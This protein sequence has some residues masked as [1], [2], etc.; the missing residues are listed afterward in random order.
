MLHLLRFMLQQ[1]IKPSLNRKGNSALACV[2]RHVRD[3]EFRYELIDMLLQHGADANCVGKDGSVPLIV[4]FVPLL[5]KGLLH[6][7][8]HTKKVS[9]LN[10]VRILCKFGANPNCAWRTNLTPLHVLVFSASEYITMMNREED[11][12]TAFGFI[13]QVLTILLQHNLDPNVDFSQRNQ[14]I[15]LAL[16]DLVQNARAPSDLEFVADLSLTLMQFGANPDVRICPVEPTIIHSQSSVFIKKSSNHVSYIRILLFSFGNLFFFVLKVLY[17]YL[18]HLL[19]K[20]ELLIDDEPQHFL[21]LILLYYHAMSHNE[22][23]ACLNHINKELLSGTLR[24]NST[25]LVNHLAQLASQPRSLKSISRNKVYL[26]L[27]RQL[28]PNINK[29]QLPPSL[30]EYILQFLP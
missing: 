14:H 6:L 10:C 26:C 22:L 23:F 15:L 1:G 28:A 25:I 17:Y 21:R 13:R 12:Q 18:Q 29:L 3:W 2:L 16:L 24:S 20:E 9:Y 19:K 7:L 11:K 8:T 5:N 27:R 4:C 30:K